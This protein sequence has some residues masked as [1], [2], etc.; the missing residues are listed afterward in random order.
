ME[1][2]EMTNPTSNPNPMSIVMT[3]AVSE[4]MSNTRIVPTSPDVGTTSETQNTLTTNM[5]ADLTVHT[6]DGF[7]IQIIGN[8]ERTLLYSLTQFNIHD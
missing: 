1:S 6:R 3:T 8:R 4:E 2:T 7:F 5:T